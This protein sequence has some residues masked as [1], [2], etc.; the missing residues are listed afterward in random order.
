MLAQQSGDQQV[1]DDDDDDDNAFAGACV[2]KFS[3]APEQQ[4]P[5]QLLV[6]ALTIRPES[7]I[8]IMVLFASLQLQR[9]DWLT[10]IR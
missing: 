9:A 2:P 3:I 5:V 10:S 8:M 4:A 1:N 7:R 6:V